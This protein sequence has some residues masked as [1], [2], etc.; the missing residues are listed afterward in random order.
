MKQLLFPYIK[1]CSAHRVCTE[2]NTY[3][4]QSFAYRRYASLLDFMFVDI[5]T[6]PT[7]SH[8]FIFVSCLMSMTKNWANIAFY[9][10]SP[11][12]HHFR[13]LTYIK[14]IHRSHS[15]NVLVY[16]AR[17]FSEKILKCFYMLFI[18]I[19]CETKEAIVYFTCFVKNQI[20][21]EILL[22]ETVSFYLFTN[23]WALP[24][25]WRQTL[26]CQMVN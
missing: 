2:L 18:Y 3:L 12:F 14:Y 19:L 7:S 20:T 25:Y 16:R 4:R 21:C 10:Q 15:F 24:I 9:V 5:Y 26:A 6:Y 22:K 8:S 13:P 1:N 11:I 17:L 23:F